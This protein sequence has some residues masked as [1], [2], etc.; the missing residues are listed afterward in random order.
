MIEMRSIHTYSDVSVPY[1]YRPFS[2]PD[3]CEWFNLKDYVSVPDTAR[4]VL[5]RNLHV[6]DKCE[7]TFI[8][9]YV[10]MLYFWNYQTEFSLHRKL[11]LVRIE[12][13]YNKAAALRTANI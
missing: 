7:S 10:R 6:T 9:T 2:A 11:V 12:V 5:T 13:W 1:Q 4:T 3:M 8:R